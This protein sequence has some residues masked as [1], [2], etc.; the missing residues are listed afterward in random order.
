M[1]NGERWKNAEITWAETAE[2][3]RWPFRGVVAEPMWIELLPNGWVEAFYADS[4]GY[5]K[6][7]L[8]PPSAFLRIGF[9]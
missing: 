1:L 6:R 4:D 9:Q 5:T 8:Y 2:P 7:M 3:Y